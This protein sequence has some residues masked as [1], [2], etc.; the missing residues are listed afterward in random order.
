[1]KIF[2]TA[3]TKNST[4]YNLENRSGITY[5]IVVMAG[6]DVE[7]LKV[8]DKDVY[9]LFEPGNHYQLT[10]QLEVRNGRYSEW[11]VDGFVQN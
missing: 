10:G 8:I 7:K 2:T 11:R 1:M 3:I 5:R 9:D 6:D 4:P